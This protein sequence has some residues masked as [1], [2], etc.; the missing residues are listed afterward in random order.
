M[1]LARVLLADD[2]VGVLRYVCGLLGK[3]FAI[4]GT[5][6]D[7]QQ[8]IDATLRLDPDVL[9]L[10]I[11]MPV[12]NGFQA[13]AHLRDVKWRTKIV[14]LT[15]YEDREYISEAFSSGASAYVAKRHLATDLVM[16]IRAVLGGGT[17]ISP[18]IAP[19]AVNGESC[20]SR[21]RT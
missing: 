15:A 19:L 1:A 18:L 6:E 5:V 8:A 17:F 21:R 2:H 13:A 20:G 10:D 11:S 7:G 16:A 12:L 14:I 4:I 3:V 9:V